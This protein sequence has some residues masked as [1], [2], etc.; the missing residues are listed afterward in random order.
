[1]TGVY[2]VAF[3]SVACGAA[4]CCLAGAWASLP[5]H[6]RYGNAKR[7]RR[8]WPAGVMSHKHGMLIFCTCVMLHARACVPVASG[9]L[10][11]DFASAR[12]LEAGPC[13]KADVDMF[14]YAM[15]EIL[16]KNP[17]ELQSAVCTDV[18]K[19]SACWR[20]ALLALRVELFR[21]CRRCSGKQHAAP[22][23]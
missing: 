2:S 1:L 22:K 19:V 4:L 14:R 9:D 11:V 8:T 16:G 7:P 10:L 6:V 18:Q 20:C 13:K 15:N 5:E 23:M 3:S 12:A 17:F 21:V